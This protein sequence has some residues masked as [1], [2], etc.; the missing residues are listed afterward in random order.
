MGDAPILLVMNLST[1]P[2]RRLASAVSSLLERV[3]V[4]PSVLHVLPFVDDASGAVQDEL[5]ESWEGEVEFMDASACLRSA[6]ESARADVNE[7]AAELRTQLEEIACEVG[8]SEW[9]E[10]FGE[11]WWY[12]HTSEKNSQND[13]VWWD[14][15]RLGAV[16]RLLA[17][18]VY[19]ECLCVGD[20]RLTGLVEQL[21]GA[22]GVRF[23]GKVIGGSQTRGARLL[24]K[25]ILGGVSLACVVSYA[26]IA[27]GRAATDNAG[28]NRKVLLAFSWVEFWTHR[29]GVW[30]DRYY[31]RTLEAAGELGLDPKCVLSL[32]GRAYVP[33]KELLRRLRDLRRTAWRQA[34]FL[35]LEAHGTPWRVIRE[36]CRARDL[37]LY[38]RMTRSPSFRSAFTWQG[39]DTTAAFARLMWESV[40][41]SWPRL[42]CQ[43]SETA[44]LVE[45]VKPAVA[46]VYSYEFVFG[47]AFVRGIRQA[48]EARIVGMQHG[49]I[50]P[51][52]FLH[53]GTKDDL[54][55]SR[56]GG[57]P[58]PSPH[59]YS[60]DGRGAKDILVRRGVAPERIRVNGA[61]RCDAVWEKARA[62]AKR[63]RLRESPIRVLVASGLHDTEFVVRFTLRALRGHEHLEI[64][65]KPHPKIASRVVENIVRS[66]SSHE[67]GGAAKVRVVREVEIY[68]RLE[69]CDLLV[70][71]YSLAAV[72]AIA[73]GVPVV[74]LVPSQRPDMSPLSPWYGCPVLT[75]SD[76]KTLR[77]LVDRLVEDREFSGT[78][79]REL[80]F[81]VSEVFGRR[82]GRAAER[83]ATTCRDLAMMDEE[84]NL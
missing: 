64:T 16:R 5:R 14:F 9:G 38:W 83:L 84:E 10:R 30:T 81:S 37:F 36:Y 62:A 7:F 50:T 2:G 77:S 71:S 35:V 25:R 66:D 12:T 41:V 53:T 1:D 27:Y 54:A 33:A 18:G 17:E 56:S 72:E 29:Y 4:R 60:L 31:G 59:V 13:A 79:L 24:A 23:S 49:A 73:F 44:A 70:A 11:L 61:A 34:K 82:D 76:A 6:G 63:P 40:V 19:S 57:P 67:S 80:D 8:G 48:G 15:V 39:V 51:M 20:E 46:L 78:Y 43:Q 69:R 42:I 22:N 58:L 65:I 45:R 74:V 55:P 3:G 28:S 32:H 75:A 52:N 47:R 68:D 26:R 21:C